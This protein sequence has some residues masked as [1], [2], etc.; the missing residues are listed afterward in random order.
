M[1][2]IA[3]IYELILFLVLCAF[4]VSLSFIGGA[5]DVYITGILIV[6]AIFAS[7]AEH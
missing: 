6:W 7:P 5:L 2:I 4:L 3:K 1:K